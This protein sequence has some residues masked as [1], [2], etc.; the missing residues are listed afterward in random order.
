LAVAHALVA[1]SFKRQYASTID[2]SVVDAA[3]NAVDETQL[4][5]EGLAAGDRRGTAH[6]FAER[7][8]N[9][10]IAQLIQ[11]DAS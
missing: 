8:F 6:G 5:V 9:Q 4:S 10:R 2:N 3:N 1:Q 7:G 11:M